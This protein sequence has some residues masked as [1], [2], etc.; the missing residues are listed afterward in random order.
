MNELKTITRCL[1]CG[2][3][4]QPA[5]SVGP[6]RQ[7]RQGPAGIGIDSDHAVCLNCWNTPAGD[8]ALAK[9]QAELNAGEGQRRAQA[10]IEARDQVRQR[11]EALAAAQKA[12]IEHTTQLEKARARLAAAERARDSL[13]QA[14][15]AAELEAKAA[16]LAAA[17]SIE[18][19]SG[20]A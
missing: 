19:A 17:A 12:V 9:A 5:V 14:A 11:E 18:Y 15:K 1:N 13:I 8:Q 10:V 16:A 7:L 20:E 2:K 6:N 3:T 4:P